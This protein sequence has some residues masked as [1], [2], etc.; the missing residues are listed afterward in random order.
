MA[1]TFVCKAAD[2]ISS[3][4]WDDEARKFVQKD[5]ES[6]I[7]SKLSGNYLPNP[8]TLWEQRCLT[9]GCKR[10]DFNGQQLRPSDATFALYDYWQG[11]K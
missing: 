5:G 3:W 8:T 6:R 7:V 11:V 1:Q 4:Y 10:S 2:S 9:A